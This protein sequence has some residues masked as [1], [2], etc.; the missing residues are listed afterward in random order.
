MGRAD[1]LPR[2]TSRATEARPAASRGVLLVNL[3]SPDAPDPAALRRYLDEFLMDPYVLDVP[4]PVRRLIVSCFILPF[5]PRRSAEAYRAIWNNASAGNGAPLR[6]HTEMLR[7]RL[8][9]HTDRPITVGM[10]YG[11]PELERAISDLVAAGIDEL[12]LMPL[13]PQ[14]ADSTRTTTIERVRGILSAQAPSVALRVLPAFYGEPR[15]LDVLAAHTRRH[16][17]G[18]IELLLCSYHGLPERH[19]TRA[20]P[21]GRHCLATPDC[22]ESPSPAHASC[23]RHQVRATTAGL[24]A[25]LGLE[26]VAVETSFQSRLGRLPWLAPYTD[27]VLEEL[28][29]RGIT[30]IAVT[31]PAFVADNLETLEELGIRGRET[32]LAAGGESLTLLPCLNDDPAWV[33][34]LADWVETPPAE[35]EVD[36]VGR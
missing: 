17:P 15:Y 32:F 4:W 16:L 10:R 7:T 14:H 23:Y 3:G 28:P 29:A 9:A 25:R 18:D 13:Y 8:G 19:I 1:A 26:G 12:L 6:A 27:A 30:R 11:R 31:A 24:E 5:R 36:R 20:D 22:C 2:T 35:S 33:E 21:T 34:L